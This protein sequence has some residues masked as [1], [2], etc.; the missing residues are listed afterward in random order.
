MKLKSFDDAIAECSKTPHLLLGNGFSRALRDNIFAYSRLFDRAKSKLSPTAQKAF[1]KLGTTN[2]EQVMRALRD[3]SALVDIYSKEKPTAAAAMNKDMLAIREALAST[4]AESHPDRPRDVTVDE[5]R[6]CKQFL[7]HFECIYTLNYDLLLYWTAM[8]DEIE[9]EVKHDDGFRTPYTGVAEYVTWEV[10]NTKKQNI[11]Y[12]HGA[13]HIFD[14]GAELQKY[15]WANTQIALI[16]QIREAL[17]N[18]KFPLFVSEGT[19]EEK[20]DRIQHSNYLGRGYRSFAAI[21]KPLFIYGV[22]LG[23][24]DNHI[25]RLIEGGGIKDVYVGVFGNPDTDWNKPMIERAKKLGSGRHKDR[26]LKVHFY[27]AASAQVWDRPAPVK[28][29]RKS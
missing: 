13:I 8:Q 6:A 25:L 12:L 5:Y 10:Q 16:D 23:D 29:P 15:T 17:A 3:A 28:K 18:N 24:S 27:D 14:A 26:P 21:E 2:F 9:P 7:S 11:F 19:A 1:S 20:L 4:I 22:S